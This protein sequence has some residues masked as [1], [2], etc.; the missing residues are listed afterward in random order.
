MALRL[1][2]RGGVERVVPAES[3]ARAQECRDQDDVDAMQPAAHVVRGGAL[4]DGVAEDW[5]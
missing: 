2:L 5:S 4:G 3:L 1:R